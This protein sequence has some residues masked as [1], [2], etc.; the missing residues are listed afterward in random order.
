[1]RFIFLSIFS[2]LIFFSFSSFSNEIPQPFGITLGIDLDFENYEMRIRDEGVGP[3]NKPWKI[4]DYYNGDSLYATGQIREH[5]SGY[6]IM[7]M[8]FNSS[9]VPNP[10]PLFEHY[11]IFLSS[12]SYKLVIIE[13][14]KEYSAPK[15]MEEGIK[16]FNDSIK[17][18]HTDINI[19][20]GKLMNKYNLKLTKDDVYK[21]KKKDDFVEE[22]HSVNK[23][24]ENEE[25]S[26]KLRCSDDPWD[27]AAIAGRIRY[28]LANAVEILSSDVTGLNDDGL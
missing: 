4:V 20:Q 19:L 6:P 7:I 10:N 17:K 26:V 23:T 5:E 15:T 11:G 27:N 3:L 8:R 18:C 13:A 24:L 14:V 12:T 16:Q 1:M 2:Y 21:L 25:F 28:E 22:V 9:Q